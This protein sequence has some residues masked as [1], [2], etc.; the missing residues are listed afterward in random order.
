MK[1]WGAIFDFDGVIANSEKKHEKAWQAVAKSRNFVLDRKVF[2]S[3]F[4]LKN[5]RFIAENLKWTQDIQ[6]IRAIIAD[7][8]KLYQEIVRNEGVELVPGVVG[9]LRVLAE[10]G[11]KCAIGSSSIR[12]N[13]DM[14]LRQHGIEHDF[15]AIIS[16]ELVHHGK[17]HPE[18][19]LLCA[20][21]LSIAPSRCVVFEDAPAGIAAAKAGEMVAV[22]I[23]TTFPKE[24]FLALSEGPDRIISSFE[25]LHFSTIAALLK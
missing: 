9:W 8:E 19:F 20:E 16:G 12:E 2:L 22:A 10:K 14:V 4:G 18:V 17:P 1:E 15:G 11:I 7:K 24:V 23:T 3:G 5:E 25:N 6:E 21:K 13:I